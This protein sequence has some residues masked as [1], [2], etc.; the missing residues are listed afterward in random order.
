[1][2]VLQVFPLMQIQTCK[3][4]RYLLLFFFGSFIVIWGGVVLLL[5]W[6]LFY[7]YY[8]LGLLQARS[9]V[10]SAALARVLLKT[11]SESTGEFSFQQVHSISRS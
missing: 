10:V 4:E 2:H 1:M 5:F 6:G 8:S 7:C 11:T 3:P 9:A